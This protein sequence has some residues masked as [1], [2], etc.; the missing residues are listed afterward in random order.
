ML[1]FEEET[2][3]LNSE[4]TVV[5]NKLTRILTKSP[6]CHYQLELHLSF[7]NH[8]L[9]NLPKIILTLVFTHALQS[10][11][12]LEFLN[13]EYVMF[14]KIIFVEKWLFKPNLNLLVLKLGGWFFACGLRGL[15]GRY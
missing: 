6:I 1:Y 13:S 7:S 2:M 4:I 15:W 9:Q 10:E 12:K 8:I 14:K 3:E 5:N 11:Q